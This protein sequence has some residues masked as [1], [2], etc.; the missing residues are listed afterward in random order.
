MTTLTAARTTPT[1]R[2]AIQADVPRLQD[3]F[4]EFVAS[5]QYARYVGNSPEYSAGLI[6]RLIVNDDGII[7]VA[8]RDALVIGMLALLAYQHPM[9]GER[10]AQEVF[11]WLDPAHRGFGVFLLRRGERW[12][13]SQGARRLSLMAPADKPR[14][15]EIYEA[16]GYERVEVTFQKD[17]I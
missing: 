11:W 6:E 15:M 14:V 1:L 5:T 12:A 16:I 9:S 8:E 17:L 7:L 3:M 13:K 4:A 2:E 10:V